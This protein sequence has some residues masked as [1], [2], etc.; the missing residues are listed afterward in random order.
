V[1]F[2]HPSPW[3]IL[4]PVASCVSAGRPQREAPILAADWLDQVLYEI[5]L[6]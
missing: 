4:A 3:T 1:Q 6:G 2:C 5:G